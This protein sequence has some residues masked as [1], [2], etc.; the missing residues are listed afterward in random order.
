MKIRVLLDHLSTFHVN[1]YAKHTQRSEANAAQ[2]LIEIGFRTWMRSQDKAILP[3]HL[4]K[5]IDDARGG[6]KHSVMS[7]RLPDGVATEIRKRAIA[8]HRSDSAMISALLADAL[9][10]KAT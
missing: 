5:Q 9:R 2:A 3:P 1:T 6:E 10:N 7:V 4:F 8:E